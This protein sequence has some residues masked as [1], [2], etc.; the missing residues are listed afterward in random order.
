MEVI[1]TPE[2]Y[3][4]LL[5]WKKSGNK[6]VQSK[7]SILLKSICANPFEGIGKPEPLQYNL[8]GKWSRRINKENRIIYSVQDKVYIYSLRGHY[9]RK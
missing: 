3:E 5:F 1:F 8:S 9:K 2:A 6:S 4:D 7:I